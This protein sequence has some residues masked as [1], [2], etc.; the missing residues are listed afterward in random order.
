MSRLDARFRHLLGTRGEP[1]LA[2]AVGLSAAPAP[3]ERVEFLARCIDAAGLKALR[4]AG[5]RIH[6]TSRRSQVI[7]TGTA[8]LAALE[9]ASGHPSIR[10]IES[11]RPMTPDLDLTCR[12]TG[13]A[14]LHAGD[15][16]LRGQ[17]TLVGI[18]DGGIDFTHPDFRRAD[19]STRIVAFWDQAGAS[20]AGEV[21]YGRVYSQAE[22][23]AALGSE[24][25][26]TQVQHRDRLG[27]GT[28]VAGIAAGN[29]LADGGRFC[30]IAPDA[31]L[32][33]VA[34]RT[35]ANVTLGRSKRAL[36][37][38]LWLIGKAAGR[39]VS[40]NISQ[41]MNGGGHAG[42]T[43]LETGID[44]QLRQPGVVVVKSAGNEQLWRI[45][46]GGQVPQGH[47]VRVGLEVPTNDRENDVVEI[48]HHG[49]DRISVT[50]V[51]PHGEPPAF[52]A[53]GAEQ[54]FQTSA[55]NEVS[56]Y[57]DLDMDETGD[58]L[59]TVLF[60][61]GSAPFIQPG[62]WSLLLRGDQVAR[63]R[64]DAW[65][66]RSPRGLGA[67]G[68]QMRFADGSADDTR[69]I[70]VPGT[71]RRV[72]TVGSF[73]T[74]P[75]AGSGGVAGGLS[76]FSSR[77]PTRYGAHKP[78]IVAPGE[79]VISCR[80]SQG[81]PAEPGSERYTGMP[82]TSMAAPHV[83][84]AAALLLSVRPELTCE[85]VKQL[86]TRSARRDGLA[87]AAP[88]DSWG[89]G[90]LD[91]RAA[92]EL[93]RKASFP[94]ISNVRVNGSTVS[95]NTDAPATAA[96]LFSASRRM[97]Q[98]GKETASKTH[99]IPRTSHSADLGDLPVGTYLCEVVAYS[100]ENFW[101]ADDNQGAYYPVVVS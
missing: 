64:F 46:A 45:H 59:T 25:P 100:G 97:L 20:I 70:S 27:H 81:M 72:I 77:G 89:H 2:E 8:T 87:A 88:D 6:F 22:I 84:G 26:F 19:G 69:T 101:T 65:I 68:E 32:L 49:D 39:P 14:E 16:V 5:A 75:E 21:P 12:G 82:G 7:V 44:E 54:T 58:T 23:D 98:L 67:E 78:E 40:I 38:V 1:E 48:W 73:I 76:G 31:D 91:V 74:R 37:A 86:L 90:R 36:D 92:V 83:A 94:V 80:T 85:Q 4:D 52:V 62:E 99:L 63:G 95:W 51:P 33:V 61:R 3:Q 42:E 29:G 41:G 34:C 30:G 60:S 93:A 18:V 47:T 15:P 71:A 17:G 43:L 56:V 11:S 9:T 24:D 79:V 57:S 96:V 66:E 53:P 13:A 55:G 35:E 28:H 10:R 50:V